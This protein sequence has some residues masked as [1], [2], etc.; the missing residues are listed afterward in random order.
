MSEWLLICV[1]DGAGSAS[2]SHIG[3]TLACAEFETQ[4]HSIGPETLFLRESMLEI[5]ARV[6]DALL[7]EAVTLNIS[8]R[9]LACTVL[10]SVVGPESAV[11]AQIGDGAIVIPDG[12]GFRVVFW[13]EPAEYANTTDFLTD[14]KFAETMVFETILSPIME[15]AVFTDGL[16]RLTLDFGARQPFPR[17]FQPMFERVR[18][19]DDPELLAPP[20][21]DFLDSSRVNDRTDDDKTL[22]LAV[23]KA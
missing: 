2:H 6:R 5:F 10:I 4:V 22:V 14:E 17:F 16:Q 12:T 3:A 19:Q 13:P 21:R 11:F 8:H 18:S 23:R 9:E 1:A 20:F 15:L 7:A